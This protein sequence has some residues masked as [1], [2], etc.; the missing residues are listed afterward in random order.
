MQFTDKQAA[1]N[2]PEQSADKL[3]WSTVEREESNPRS[4]SSAAT[5]PQTLICQQSN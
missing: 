2:W 3:A 1:A 4:H 5:L